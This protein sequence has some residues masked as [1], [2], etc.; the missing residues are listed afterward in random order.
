M[1]Q[2]CILVAD[3]ARARLF[4]ANM[5]EESAKG[6]ELVERQD[7]V[8]PER[9]LADREIFSDKAGRNRPGSGFEDHRRRHRDEVERKFAKRIAAAVAQELQGEPAD[10]L[11]VVADPRLLGLLRGALDTSVP[12]AP[13][14]IEVSADLTWQALPRLQHALAQLGVLPD[15]PRYTPPRHVPPRDP[16][17]VRRG[18]RASMD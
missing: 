16:K 11:V 12:G 2:W 6:A 7:L 3:G 9:G 14:R 17:R 8:E 18:G 1:T 4:R 5:Q 10:A 13:P 15:R